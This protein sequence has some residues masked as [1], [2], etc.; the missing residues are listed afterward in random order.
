MNVEMNKEKEI[1]LKVKQNIL[2]NIQLDLQLALPKISSTVY[3]R[4]L[5]PFTQMSAKPPAQLP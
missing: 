2:I 1:L 3:L 4:H 5:A